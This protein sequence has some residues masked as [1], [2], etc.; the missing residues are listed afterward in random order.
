MSSS[1]PLRTPRPR[2]ATNRARWCCAGERSADL[3][4]LWEGEVEVETPDGGRPVL[5]APNIFGE[6]SL[7]SAVCG[8]RP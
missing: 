2:R 1:W 5:A 4:I 6:L 3:Y 7:I 8:R